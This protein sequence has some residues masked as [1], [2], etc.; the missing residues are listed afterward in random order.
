V[1]E[2]EETISEEQDFLNKKAPDPLSEDIK[3]ARK[4]NAARNSVMSRMY[5]SWVDTTIG[6]DILPFITDP[7]K[8]DLI[9]EEGKLKKVNK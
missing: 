3:D 6:E 2:V 5:E 9:F 1:K 7:Q 8:D 4:Y